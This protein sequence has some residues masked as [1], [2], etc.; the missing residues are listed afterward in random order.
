MFAGPQGIARPPRGV[1]LAPAHKEVIV[2]D[3]RVN[4]VMTWYFPEM[5]EGVD[6]SRSSLK[7]RF[8]VVKAAPECPLT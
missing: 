5:F 1:T 7:N 4:A 8:A 2:T 6:Q 3:K